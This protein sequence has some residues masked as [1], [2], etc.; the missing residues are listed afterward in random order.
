MSVFITNFSDFFRPATSLNFFVF[1]V[2]ALRLK[3]NNVEEY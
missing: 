1:F 3:S 2:L